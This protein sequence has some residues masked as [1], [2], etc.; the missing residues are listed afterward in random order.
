VAP[1]GTKDIGVHSRHGLG[2]SHLGN[3]IKHCIVGNDT[4]GDH[5]QKQPRDPLHSS[6]LVAIAVQINHGEI[7]QSGAYWEDHIEAKDVDSILDR[8]EHALP[9][10]RRIGTQYLVDGL[11]AREFLENQ[12][13]GDAGSFYGDGELPAP[14]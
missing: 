14:P 11:A 2:V 13:D 1:R 9:S 3:R 10:Q 7:S 12:F 6:R 8:R 5:I 4:S